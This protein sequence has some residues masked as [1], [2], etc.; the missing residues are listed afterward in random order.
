MAALENSGLVLMPAAPDALVAAPMMAFSVEHLDALP[1]DDDQ[2][3]QL[4]ALHDVLS[5]PQ[6]MQPIDLGSLDHASTP[7]AAPAAYSASTQ[8]DLSAY[9]PSPLPLS[10]EE[11]QLH[12]VAHL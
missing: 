1:T 7:A 10:H 12:A 11:E 9:A 8:P 3:A 5:T 2:S 4:P 6:A